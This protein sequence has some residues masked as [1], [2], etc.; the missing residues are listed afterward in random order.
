MAGHPLLST[1]DI[2]RETGLTPQRIWQLAVAGR[3]PAKRANPGGKQYRFYDSAEFAAWRKEQRR[4]IARPVGR[5]MTHAQRISRKRRERIERLLKILREKE[6]VEPHD[7]KLA[8][9][10]LHALFLLLFAHDLPLVEGIHALV[11][12]KF[13]R[14]SGRFDVK[15]IGLLNSVQKAIHELP[16]RSA[17]KRPRSSNAS[18]R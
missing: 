6:A 16:T 10:Y 8:L 7:K 12:S 14:L 9:H 5:T 11:E 18:A 2:A 4:R 15:S 13:F 17:R 3:I 1:G